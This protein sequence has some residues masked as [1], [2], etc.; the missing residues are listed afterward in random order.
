MDLFFFAENGGVSGDEPAVL[1]GSAYDGGFL[2]VV[3]HDEGVADCGGVVGD[4]ASEIVG[5]ELE[6]KEIGF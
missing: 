3:L 2:G 4:D 6:R 1:E 5:G